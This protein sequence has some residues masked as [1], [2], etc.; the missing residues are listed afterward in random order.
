MMRDKDNP[1]KTPYDILAEG[2]K[3][4]GA[5][6]V[7]I[8]S[9]CRNG[10]TVT[11]SSDDVL[12]PHLTVAQVERLAATAVY[13]DRKERESAQEIRLYVDDVRVPTEPGWTIARTS[14][15]AVSMLSTKNV[16]KC[17]LD[18]DLGGEDTGYKVVCWMEENG[19][20]PRDGVRC[21]SANPVGRKR[22]QVVID[23]HCGR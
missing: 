19:V 23:R 6:R 8:Q 18:H 14:E 12:V 5:L 1:Y 11:W 10:D 17:S 4:L 21:H 15:E 22:I 16:I 2:G 9:M 3:W 20:W 7:R 13:A